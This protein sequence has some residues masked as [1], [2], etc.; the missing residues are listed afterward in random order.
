MNEHAFAIV[1]LASVSVK[2]LLMPECLFLSES[3]YLCSAGVSDGEN[4]TSKSGGVRYMKTH[5]N[6]KRAAA[7]PKPFMPLCFLFAAIVIFF[8]NFSCEFCKAF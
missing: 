6:D 1:F 7:K 8:Y 2:V 4:E 3:K 5:A